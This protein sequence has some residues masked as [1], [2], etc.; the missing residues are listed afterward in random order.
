MKLV[1]PF[2]LLFIASCAGTAP[3]RTP[4]SEVSFRPGIVDSVQS[5]VRLFPDESDG[6]YNFYLETKNDNG[7]YVDADQSEIEVLTKKGLSLP[8]A[9]ERILIGRY[10]LVIDQQKV[11]SIDFVEVAVQGKHLPI[12]F[13]LHPHRPDKK[14][15][16]LTIIENHDNIML[17]RLRLANTE[18]KAIELHD[19]PEILFQGEGYVSEPEEKGDGIWEFSVIYP[20]ANQ[21]MYFSIRAHG[22]Y[23]HRIFRYQHIEK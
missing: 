4:S 6:G 17:L 23:L 11:N 16:K 14:H 20:E 19:R 3:K 8:Y 22:I 5:R 2:I 12:K 13:K 21:I 10:Y 15:T 7:E 9:F 1:L 18:N